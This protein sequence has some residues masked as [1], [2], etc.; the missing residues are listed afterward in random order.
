MQL[1]FFVNKKEISINE[2]LSFGKNLM[3]IQT[4]TKLNIDIPRFCYHEKLSIA[5]NCRLCLVEVEKSPKPVASCAI[6]CMAGMQIFTESL[7]VK[8]A[9]EGILEFLLINHPLDCPICDWGGECDLQD[10]TETFGGD[11][12]RFYELKRAVVDKNYSPFIKT[13]M[14]RCIHCTRCIRFS[15]EIAGM[16]YLGTTGR[17]GKMEVGIFIEKTF[18]SELSGNMIDLCPVGALTSKPYQFAGRPW[19]LKS[20][21]SIDVFDSYNSNIRVDFKDG[22]VLRILPSLNENINEEWISDKIRF[23]YDSLK[24]QRLSNP[25]LKNFKAFGIS[26]YDLLLSKKKIKNDLNYTVISWNESFLIFFFFFKSINQKNLVFNSVFGSFLDLKSLVSFKDLLNLFH[27]SSF[28]SKI[29][30][31]SQKAQ[32]CKINNDFRTH[33][34]LNLDFSKFNKMETLLILGLDLKN[35]S[36]VFN[37]KLRKVILEKNLQVFSIGSNINTVLPLK[38]IGN[39][40]FDFLSILEGN[41]WLCNIISK[42]HGLIILFHPSFTNNN[43]YLLLNKFE[44][45]FNKLKINLKYSTILLETSAINAM[46]SGLKLKTLNLKKDVYNFLYLCSVDESLYLKNNFMNFCVYQ[47]HHGDSLIFNANLILPSCTFLEKSGVY[48]NIQGYY[49]KVNKILNKFGNSRSDFVIF[50][51]LLNRFE[52][53]FNNNTN[54]KKLIKSYDINLRLIQ[55]LGESSDLDNKFCIETFKISLNKNYLYKFNFCKILGKTY[56]NNFYSN[57]I[58]SKSSINLSKAAKEHKYNINKFI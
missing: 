24:V 22:E 45:L 32:Y 21:K 7:L 15:S 3:V 33:Y 58:L 17:G 57:D 47:S 40:F 20:L 43:L 38:K 2:A 53:L 34:L 1:T 31:N 27:K 50:S 9:R 28:K 37:Y 11:Q 8:K 26:S 23:F 55:V 29:Y 13:I 54:N 44:N 14:T 51:D 48:L 39:N 46:E 18:I 4:C 10:L 49:Q 25:Q 30:I 12:G 36:P 19:E 6:S 52:N 56:I 41:H 42:S 5:G 35:E 16:P